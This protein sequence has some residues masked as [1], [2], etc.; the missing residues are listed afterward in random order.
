MA[1]YEICGTEVSQEEMKERPR[2]IAGTLLFVAL[3]VLIVVAL[4]ALMLFA[5]TRGKA[6]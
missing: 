1:H 2:G 5:L 3:L 4:G 6:Q